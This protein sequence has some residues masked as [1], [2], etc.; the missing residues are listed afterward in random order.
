MIS[1]GDTSLICTLVRGIPKMQRR[2]SRV[3][4]IRPSGVC[5]FVLFAE[6]M[7]EGF[8]DMGRGE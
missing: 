1:T 3:R 7:A 8:Q 4:R 2:L 6:L 5:V